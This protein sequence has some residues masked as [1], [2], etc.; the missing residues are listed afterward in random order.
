MSSYLPTTPPSAIT[1]G[2]GQVTNPWF[3]VANQFVPRNLHEVIKWA[4]YIT[5][6]SPTTSEVIRKHSTYPITEFVVDTKNPSTEEKYD[7]ILKSIRLKEFLQ[8]TGFEYHTIGNAFISIYFPIQRTL[9]CPHCKTSYSSKAAHFVKFE[10]YEFKG[11]CPKCGSRSTFI[12]KDSKSTNVQDINLIRWNAEHIRVNHNPITGESEY[13][14][15]IPNSVKRRVQLGDRLFVDSI[16][17][18]FVDAIKKNQE[19]K[20]DKGNIFHL[21]NVTTGATVEGI[22]VPPLLSLFGL[23]F[24]QA[25]LRKANEAIAQDF[26][27]PM[28]VIFPQAQTG[29]SD[30]VVAMSMRNFVE[31]MEDALKKHK[32]DKNHILVAPTPVGYSPIG[33]EGR[34]LLVATEIQQA[35]D[36]ILMSLGV[37]RELLTGTSNWTS[38]SVGLRMLENTMLSYVSRLQ[39]LMDWAIVRI[40][41]Y[42]GIERCSVTLKPFKLIDDDGRRQAL[43][44]L[45]QTGKVSDTTLL[46]EV[47]VDFLEEQGHFKEEQ[48]SKAKNEMATQYEVQ[49]AQ[50]LSAREAGNSMRGNDEAKSL[51]EKAEQMANELYQAEE[52]ARRSVLSQ[53]KTQDYTQW[54]LVSKLLEE[55]KKSTEHQQAIDQGVA[56]VANE[57]EGGEA[58]TPAQPAPP[59]DAGPVQ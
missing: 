58:S 24:Y 37:S 28:R 14:Y 56:Q 7:E 25:T 30:P 38:S 49:V 3:T 20:F 11:V 5:I 33:G 44:A 41:T 40:A 21:Q 16:P 12:R 53:L 26:L 1:S 39:E 6:Q 48:V 31:R 47:G 36:T 15:T 4:R 32:Q 54:L 8:N 35:E 52:G 27:N 55:Y 45:S 34:N 50:T 29:N 46:K 13:Y 23:V 2:A 17:W 22:S 18:G 19:F 43:V 9:E 59:T 42:L 10:K 51:I 57:T